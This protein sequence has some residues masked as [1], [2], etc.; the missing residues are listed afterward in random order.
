MKENHNITSKQW[1]K[2]LFVTQTGVGVITLPAVV[3]QR[4]GHDGWIIIVIVG[5]IAILLSTLIVIFLNRYSNKSVYEINK[6]L[7]GNL[8]GRAFNFILFAY[9]FI[10]VVGGVRLFQF[11]IRVS[12]M[13]QTPFW[14]LSP[15]ILA[16]S[17]YLVW[18][19]LKPMAIFLNIT[20]ISYFMLLIYLAVLSSNYRFS[21]LLPVGEAGILPLLINAHTG[22]FAF[23]GFEI[24][25]F[26]YPFITDNNKVM[27]WQNISIIGSILFFLI[28]VVTSIA[29]FGANFLKIQIL[30]I[31]MMAR[32]FN[33]PV[34]ER[35]DLYIV[36]L[37]F[38]PITCSMRTYVFAAYYSI[39]KV[40]NIQKSKLWYGLFFAV[41]I[42]LSRIPEN[43][44]Q[45][46]A[47][48]DIIN[49]FG[50]G[51]IMFFVV[52]L[53]FSFIRKKGVVCK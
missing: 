9:L 8:L 20:L 22:I 21:Y 36:A 43:I 10:T 44:N 40:F 46:Y 39:E 41:A 1:A 49:Y 30:P 34:L 2:M 53:L 52:S 37:W 29:L 38:I 5:L 24:I 18:Q 25:V 51:V 13:P 47:F 42:A 50:L 28:V 27:K 4:V 31:F 35:V 26:I 19:G 48:I 3:S 23:L 11:F 15:F 7:Y 12:L 32:A 14:I 45:L 16:P 33:A 6:L 17:I